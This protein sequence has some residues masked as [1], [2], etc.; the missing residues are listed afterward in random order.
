MVAS[1]PTHV[2]VYY[3]VRRDSA[4]TRAAI[5]A[6]FAD[7][8]RRTGV[9]GRLLARCDDRRTWLEVYEPVTRWSSFGRALEA[10]VRANA[11]AALAEDGRRHIER[12]A[13]PPPARTRS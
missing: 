5:A 8:E 4:A 9:A 10:A 13:A 6:L 2:Y 11:A 12:F 1:A 3:R 7:V